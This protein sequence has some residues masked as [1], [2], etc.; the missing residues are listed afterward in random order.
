VFASYDDGSGQ[1]P[2]GFSY[3]PN[4]S[5]PRFGSEENPAPVQIGAGGDL[6]LTLEVWPSQRLGVGDESPGWVD[7]GQVVYTTSLSIPRRGAG[8]C[9]QEALST[10]DPNLSAYV[11][12][13]IGGPTAHQGG[14]LDNG[15]DQAPDPGNVATYRLNVTQCLAANGLSAGPG[16]LVSLSPWAYFFDG[17]RGSAATTTSSAAF[18]IR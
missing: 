5:G 9:P 6:I 3:A 12:P 2:R 14:F 17:Q 15:S 11:G 16:D 4:Q 8:F 7:V 18:L 13:T 10:T 1:G